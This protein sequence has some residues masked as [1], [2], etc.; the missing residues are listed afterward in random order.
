[1]TKMYEIAWVITDLNVYSLVLI[2]LSC[3]LHL[4]MRL[5]IGKYIGS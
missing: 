5:K 4:Y 1:M 2:C 3:I